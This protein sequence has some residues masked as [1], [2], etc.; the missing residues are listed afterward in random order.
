[1]IYEPLPFVTIMRNM[2]LTVITEIKDTGICAQI[3]SKYIILSN[4]KQ[5]VFTKR[6]R[7]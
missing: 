5:A 6:I 1:M 4:R 2:V 7:K 3:S